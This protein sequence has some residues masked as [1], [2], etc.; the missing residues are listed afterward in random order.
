[1]LF[2]ESRNKMY[3]I[4]KIIH[5]KKKKGEKCLESILRANSSSK[6]KYYIGKFAKSKK[7]EI[8]ENR[9]KFFF[10]SIY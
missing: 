2:H 8:R 3:T 10:V 6:S 4:R 1:M 5:Y 9:K 7:Y